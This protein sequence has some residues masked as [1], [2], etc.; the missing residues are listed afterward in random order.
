[1]L[2]ACP[3]LLAAD[4]TEL[5]PFFAYERAPQYQVIGSDAAVPVRDGTNITCQIYRPATPGDLPAPGEFPG[6]IFNYTGYPRDAERNGEDA[7]YYVAAGA[8]L[9]VFALR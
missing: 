9:R 5:D 3:E 1:M 4:L 8:T 6:I 2:F 7:S